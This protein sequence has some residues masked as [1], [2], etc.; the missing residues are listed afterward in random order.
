MN[1]SASGTVLGRVLN[2][3]ATK[4]IPTEALAAFEAKWMNSIETIPFSAANGAANGV[5]IVAS[6][7]TVAVTVCVAGAVTG[8]V[9]IP[10]YIDNSDTKVEPYPNGTRTVAASD[11]IKGRN[12][13]FT[14]GNCECGHVN[15]GGVAVSGLLPGDEN[16]TWRIEDESGATIA[17]GDGTNAGTKIAELEEKEA[18]G[19]YTMHFTLKDSDGNTVKLYRIFEVDPNF[20]EKYL[21]E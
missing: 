13:S 10:S 6:M 18:V 17:S 20:D 3:Q 5:K 8:A 1:E 14:G 15:P 21:L 16:V 9:V 4:L 2:G 7:K 19:S 12:I 11:F